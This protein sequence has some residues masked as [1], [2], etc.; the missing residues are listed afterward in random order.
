MALGP[1]GNCQ[2]SFKCVD[3]KTGQFLISRTVTRVLWPLNG[4]LLQKVEAWDRKG[5]CAIKSNHIYFLNRS[6][7][8]FDW[9]NKGLSELEVLDDQ[10]KLIDPGVTLEETDSDKYNQ[11]LGVKENENDKSSYTAKVVTVR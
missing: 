10:P 4:H 11:D 9:E 6:G 2:G 5:V 3:I 8:K 1:S 7:K